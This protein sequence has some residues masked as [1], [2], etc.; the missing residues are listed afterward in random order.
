MPMVISSLK[1]GIPTAP[2][3]VS[4]I[5]VKAA[6]RSGVY[7]ACYTNTIGMAKAEMGTAQPDSSPEKR[8]MSSVAVAFSFYGNNL[9]IPA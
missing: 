7:G 8:Q 4:S 2:Y 9:R 3:G 6:L 5:V 1:T